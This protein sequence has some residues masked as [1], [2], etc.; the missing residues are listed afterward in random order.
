L[1][2]LVAETKGF[3][4]WRLPEPEGTVKRLRDV[5]ERGGAEDQVDGSKH[6]KMINPQHLVRLHQLLQEDPQRVFSGYKRTRNGVPVLELR[7][8]EIAGCLRTA[9]GGSSKQF[10]VYK[11][12]SGIVVRYMT[13][14]EAARLMGAP[15]DYWLPV[16][17]N[18]AY[19]A[20]GDAV[21]VP[22]TSY[23]AKHLLVP[24]VRSAKSG[25]AATD[26][27][28]SVKEENDGD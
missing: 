1:R 9:S 16:E 3:S 22:V 21:V 4:W 20:M 27:S 11:S 10:L 12:A 25:R 19:T 18:A 15:D 5:V 24:I 6:S 28:I 8:D 17:R 7:F 2:K 23:L 14:R 13:P 26:A